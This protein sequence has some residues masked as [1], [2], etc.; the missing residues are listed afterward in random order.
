MNPLF[1]DP[2]EERK[3]SDD[4]VR[5]TLRNNDPYIDILDVG[6]GHSAEHIDAI[7]EAMAGNKRVKHVNL[8]LFGDIS[9]EQLKRLVPVLPESLDI[10]WDDPSSQK[11]VEFLKF[12]SDQ[13][14]TIK[15]LGVSSSEI[16]SIGLARAVAS[17]LESAIHL[18]DFS[19]NARREIIAERILDGVLSSN[20]E[21]LSM[22]SVSIDSVTVFSSKYLPLREL[23]LV[24]HDDV[25]TL[26][27]L[28]GALEYSQQCTL[29]HLD[30]S[31][32]SSW[33]VDEE[34]REFAALL[35][36]ACPML[37]T[38]SL[39]VSTGGVMR[40]RIL[41]AFAQMCLELP[42]LRNL[43]LDFDCVTVTPSHMRPVFSQLDRLHLSDLMNAPSIAS[44][45]FVGCQNLQSLKLDFLDSSASLLPFL[46]TSLPTLTG[47]KE[48]SFDSLDFS[49]AVET[50][51]L[52]AV[53]DL[54]CL[55]SVTL[56]VQCPGIRPVVA[57]EIYYLCMLRSV[58]GDDTL[59]NF[60]LG[61]YPQVIVKLTQLR[62]INL[63]HHLV[64]EKHNELLGYRRRL[65]S[66]ADHQ[67]SD[68]EMLCSTACSRSKAVA[69]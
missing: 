6:C 46:E 7:I 11:C 35:P 38:L 50:A 34:L 56:P 29:T 47:L 1:P 13:H 14:T 19:F 67:H 68:S 49:P 32:F 58:G 60:P 30:L 48:L 24:L 59:L 2:R 8:G 52:R 18:K 37:T 27:I 39:G 51:L 42:H 5:E 36:R 12:L 64:S 62:W 28:G 44:D 4:E 16:R 15:S 45:C 3:L 23:T 53:R 33:S 25:S 21:N 66:A 20:I 40:D 31:I 9:L 55:E 61:L 65:V 26:R 57:N 22:G 69:T 63:V 10:L 54:D 43:T 17:F 41:A